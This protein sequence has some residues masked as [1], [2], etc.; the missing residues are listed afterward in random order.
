MRPDADVRMI[1]GAGH[2]VAYEAPEQFHAI[3]LEMLRRTRP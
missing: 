3:L 2:W 1:S